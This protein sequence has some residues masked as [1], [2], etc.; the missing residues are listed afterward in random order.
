MLVLLLLLFLLSA[1]AAAAV[2]CLLS[3]AGGLVF[4]P[5]SNLA[6]GGLGPAALE[7]KLLQVADPNST[8]QQ[9]R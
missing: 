2:C 1:A 9:E 8:Q 4:M 5:S 6:L 3:A 7:P